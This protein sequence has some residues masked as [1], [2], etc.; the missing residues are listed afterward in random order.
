MESG[1]ETTLSLFDIWMLISLS[2]SDY[3][4]RQKKRKKKNIL[5]TKKSKIN[6]TDVYFVY[7]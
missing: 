2:I 4:F 3:F 7:K 5:P 6:K 1:K